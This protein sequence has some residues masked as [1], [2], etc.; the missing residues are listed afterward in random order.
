M[1]GAAAHVGKADDGEEREGNA[2]HTEAH[3]NRARLGMMLART[4]GFLS[5]IWTYRRMVVSAVS[6][7][8]V[9]TVWAVSMMMR[10]RVAFMI[11]G[12]GALVLVRLHRGRVHRELVVARSSI[13]GAIERRLAVGRGRGMI[14]MFGRR[15]AV[16]AMVRRRRR[17]R[18]RELVE[19]RV[20]SLARRRRRDI[21]VIRR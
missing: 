4:R 8:T 16:V 19:R 2:S 17:R 21:V 5:Q 18:R 13:M 12:K 9:G 11:R 10:R 20:G 7:G 14:A 15:R 1:V 6:V 3:E